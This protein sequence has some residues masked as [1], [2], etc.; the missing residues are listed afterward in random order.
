M[1]KS[2]SVEEIRNDFFS[3]QKRTKR[4]DIT[5]TNNGPFTGRNCDGWKVN[6]ISNEKPVWVIYDSERLAYEKAA[7]FCS[8][9]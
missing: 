8:W 9:K 5:V 3:E 2:K 1:A 6:F 7:Q 4:E